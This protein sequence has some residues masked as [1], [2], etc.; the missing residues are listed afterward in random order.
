MAGPWYSGNVTTTNQTI[1]IT[2][3]MTSIY[4]YEIPAGSQLAKINMPAGSVIL[5]IEQ[6]SKG[7][8]VFAMVDTTKEMKPRY[9]QIVKTGEELPA[10]AWDANYHAV[11]GCAGL[12]ILEVEAAH[13]KK[14]A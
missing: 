14:K 9:F 12:H 4:R 5:K 3:T 2:K 7:A 13:L 1:T 8:S 10:W 6:T 11:P